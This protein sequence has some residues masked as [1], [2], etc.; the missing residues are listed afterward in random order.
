MDLCYEA[1]NGSCGK[2][3]RP[4]G[5]HVL[6]LIAMMLTTIVTVIGNILVI[7]SIGHFKQL[8]T[9]TNQ[10]ILSLALCDF[11]LGL[12]VMPLSAVRSMQ[13]CW[14]F[15]DFLF[16]GNLLIIISISHFKQLQSPTHLIVRSLAASDC[17]LG[18]L[19]MPY[20]MLDSCL[21]IQRYVVV[22]GA[23][24]AFLVLMILTT[25]FG[26]LLIIIS[27][28]HFKQLQSP[29]HLIVR[30]LAACD[31]LLGSLVMPYSMG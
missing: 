31:C 2:Y 20:S 7:I 8:H 26:N 6:M 25:V 28:S 19:V 14:Y 24:Y 16:F 4:Y 22:K 29:T 12:F 17:L 9:A 23:M 21:K 13:G 15:G 1:L 27:I 18:S 5:V 10:L 30:S 11:L 3:A